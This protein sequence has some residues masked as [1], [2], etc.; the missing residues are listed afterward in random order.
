MAGPSLRR[1]ERSR[2]MGWTREDS[3]VCLIT[4]FILTGGEGKTTVS[5]RL[6]GRHEMREPQ[7]ETVSNDERGGGEADMPS[8]V[9]KRKALWARPQP[10]DQPSQKPSVPAKH[11]HSTGH[12]QQTKGSRRARFNRGP[13]GARKNPNAATNCGSALVCCARRGLRGTLRAATAQRLCM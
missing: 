6:G 3:L 4:D 10:T 5:I 1:G 11:T 13:L 9:G 12:A 2:H 7:R 8:L